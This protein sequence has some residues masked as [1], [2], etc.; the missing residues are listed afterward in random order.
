MSRKPKRGNIQHIEIN[1]SDLT[2]S[3]GFYE[4]LLAWVGYK[5]ILDEKE[6]RWVG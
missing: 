5:R 4:D 2:K 3:K 6:V 1:V